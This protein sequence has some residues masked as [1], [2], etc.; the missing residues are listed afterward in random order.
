LCFGKYREV[1][2]FALNYQIQIKNDRIKL[3][4]LILISKSIRKSKF[5]YFLKFIYY[6]FGW[7]ETVIFDESKFL[8]QVILFSSEK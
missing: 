3:F 8:D 7:G 2:C 1:G 6:F 5:I 4:N